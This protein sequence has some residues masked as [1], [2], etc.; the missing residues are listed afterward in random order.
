MQKQVVNGQAPRTAVRVDNPKLPDQLPHI[1]FSD[2]TALN[3]DGG[4]HDAM[5]GV[6]KLTKSERIWIFKN[7]WGG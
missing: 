1:R 6:H 4:I 7:G 3:I 2:G 5:R